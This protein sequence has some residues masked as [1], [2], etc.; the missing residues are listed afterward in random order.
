MTM[1]LRKDV[2]SCLRLGVVASKRIGNAVAR[3]RAKRRLREVFR[4]NR[5]LFDTTDDAVLVARHAILK[6]DW[7]DIEKELLLLARKAGILQR[8]CGQPADS[9]G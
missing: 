1:W 8:N 3:N 9:P 6:A 5:R 4:L 2:D 7:P